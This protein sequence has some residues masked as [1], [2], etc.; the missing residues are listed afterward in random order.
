MRLK[1]EETND[2]SHDYHVTLLHVLRA[3]LFWYIP[4][5]SVLLRLFL[6]EFADR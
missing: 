3:L 1:S 5:S 4:F 6:H 2:V